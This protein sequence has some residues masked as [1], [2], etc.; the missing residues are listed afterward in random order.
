[1]REA[2]KYSGNRDQIIAGGTVL[3]PLFYPLAVE[4]LIG[5]Q[6]KVSSGRLY[7]CTSAGDFAELVVPLDDRARDAAIQVAETIGEA[8]A[9]PFLPAAPAKE[10]CS[11]CDYRP[12]C[13]PHEERRVARKKKGLETLLTLREAP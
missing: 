6:A 4:K 9:L 2:G 10:E 1:V 8:V 5:D 12:V 7:F 11:F 3:Q 13:G